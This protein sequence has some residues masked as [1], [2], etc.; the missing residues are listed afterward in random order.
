MGSLWHK[1][2]K[3]KTTAAELGLFVKIYQSLGLFTKYKKRQMYY[4]AF[5]MEQLF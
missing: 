4:V 2:R 5:Q 3:E 1:K